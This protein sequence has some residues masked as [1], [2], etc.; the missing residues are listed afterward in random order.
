MVSQLPAIYCLFTVI[1]HIPAVIIVEIKFNGVD[2][3]EIGLPPELSCIGG[4]LA[5]NQ[6]DNLIGHPLYF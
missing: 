1:S 2:R 6:A 3:I 5:H 4:D